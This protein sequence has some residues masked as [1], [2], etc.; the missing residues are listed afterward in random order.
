V[1]SNLFPQYLLTSFTQVAVAKF[2]TGEE[3]SQSLSFILH[4]ISRYEEEARLFAIFSR[5]LN[6]LSNL[7]A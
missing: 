7:F 2:E 6:A 3:I 4:Q 1:K 5:V